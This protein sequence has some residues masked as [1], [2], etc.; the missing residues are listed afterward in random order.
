MKIESG[1]IVMKLALVNLIRFLRIVGLA[2][3]PIVFLEK[4]FCS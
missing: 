2:C 3:S 1:A 4:Q